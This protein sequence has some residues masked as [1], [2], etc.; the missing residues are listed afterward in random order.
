MEN[1]KRKLSPEQHEE[2]LKTLK[3]RFEK[4]MNRHNGLEWAKVQTKLETNTE[5]LW[6]LNEMERTGGEPDVVAYDI[7][8]DE[9]IFYDCAAESPKGRRSLCYD[10]EALESR[11]EHKPKNSAIDMAADMGIEILTEEQYR[12]LQKLGNFDTKTSSWV[13]TPANI[14]KLGGAI[15]CDRRYD[16]VFKYHNGA[17]SYY[18]ARGFRGSLSVI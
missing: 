2:I 8:A 5:K 7:K 17:E 13:K 12:E 16:T 11:K 10:R 1:D 14:R 4:N 3:V 9:Y 6:S 15:F 18:A